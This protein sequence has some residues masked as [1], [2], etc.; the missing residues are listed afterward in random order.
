M[1]QKTKNIF[2]EPYFSTLPGSNQKF[3]FRTV[4]RY[5]VDSN[6]KPIE[7][8][9]STFLYYTPFANGQVPG[10]GGSTWTSGTAD[11]LDNFKQGGWTYAAK[12]DDGGKT[13]T[14]ESY[15]QGDA[16]AGRI[17]PGKKVGDE[18][19]GATTQLSLSTSGGR[20]YEATQNSIINSTVKA[21]R[22]GTAPVGLGNLVSVKQKNTT[23]VEAKSQLQVLQDK[24]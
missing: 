17:P 4:T 10:T 24:P 5:I 19:L 7:G 22:A 12:T 16:N 6:E 21:Q 8:S 18:V 2:G 9:V 20:F 23:A 15:T 13:Y 11:S 1:A 3:Y 14:F